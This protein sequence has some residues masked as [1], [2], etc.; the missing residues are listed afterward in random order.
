MGA[1]E[2]ILILVVYLLLF[3]AKGVPALAQT[4]G[5]AVYQFRNATKDVQNEIM[6]GADE[7]RKQANIR[8][9]QI[10]VDP[11]P[12]KPASQ[13]QPPTTGANDNVAS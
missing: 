10:D 2:I 6:K 11:T 12:S 8:M 1:S 13:P 3:G 7:V 4:L 5:K 9:D